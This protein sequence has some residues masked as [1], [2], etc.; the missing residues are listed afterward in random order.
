[1][2]EP[3]ILVL[4]EPTASLDPPGRRELTQ[5]LKDLP[6]AKLLV[7]HNVDFARALATRT[8]FFEGGRVA[9]EGTVDEI[10]TRFNWGSRLET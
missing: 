6:Q 5:L 1:V 7:T 3:E 2:M 8:V 4:D 9:G 10:A